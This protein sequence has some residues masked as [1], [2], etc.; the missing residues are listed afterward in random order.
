MT[1]R[2]IP[3]SS[4]PRVKNPKS[5]LLSLFCPTHGMQPVKGKQRRT[6]K[7]TLGCGCVRSRK[8]GDAWSKGQESGFEKFPD[9]GPYIADADAN[10]AAAER[11]LENTDSELNQSQGRV[12]K[13]WL[14]K[15]AASKYSSGVEY[16]ET[17]M[18]AG[19]EPAFTPVYAEGKNVL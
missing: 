11:F 4:N 19:V 9:L 18:P 12:F 16:P 5:A 8:I 7:F 17:T 10:V 15:W 6:R 1:T 14:T 13:K 2:R 3:L